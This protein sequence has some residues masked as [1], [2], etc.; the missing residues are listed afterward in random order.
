MD[1]GL[2]IVDR[3]SWIVDIG[4]WIVDHRSLIVDRGSWIVN[5]GSWIVYRWLRIV[6]RG[7]LDNLIY[8]A[9]FENVG[10]SWKT[11][12]IPSNVSLKCI[13]TAPVFLRGSFNKVN[14]VCWEL[15]HL[16]KNGVLF[17]VLLHCGLD[18]FRLSFNI[19]SK[20]SHF[21]VRELYLKKNIS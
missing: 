2:W 5:R 3:R 8:V 14:E 18:L 21:I 15:C 17:Q 7:W 6:D 4:S 1:R 16:S 13:H 12:N 11:V 20:L 19:F 10:S 9:I